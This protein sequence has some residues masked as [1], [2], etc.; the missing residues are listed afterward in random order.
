MS[1]AF[2]EGRKNASPSTRLHPLRSSASSGSGGGDSYIPPDLSGRVAVV[3]GATR[4]IGKG[5]ALELGAA[6]MTVYVAGRSDETDPAGATIDREFDGME[7]CT[8]QSTSREIDALPGPGRGVP[9]RCDVRNDDEVKALFDRVKVDNGGRLDVIVASAFATP[10]GLNTADFRTD[11]WKQGAE[12]WDACNGVGLRGSYVTCCEAA[13]LMIDTAAK[14]D[15]EDGNG[16]SSRGRSRPLMVLIS[17]FGGK[18]YTFNVAYGVGKAGADRLASDMSVQLSQKHGVD[19]VSLYPGLVRTE[20]N[21]AME[22]RGEWEE[23]S[24]GLDLGPGLAESPRFS[25]RAVAMLA[26]DP[27][28]MEDRSGKVAVVAELATELGFS[29]I[30]GSRPPSIRSLQFLLP[31]Y[32]FPEIEKESGKPLPS[33][34]TENVPNVLLPWSVFEGGPPPTK[35]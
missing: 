17:S 10:P 12:M 23:A 28:T 31:N 5:I 1:P 25:G 34:I 20:G 4:G 3:T 22:E 32:V 15:D 19:T 8:I 18:S 21:L 11:F 35:D 30:D 16:G 27:S 33:F 9:A 6:G 26:A 24:G 2:P 14:K 13:P 7:L 29:D